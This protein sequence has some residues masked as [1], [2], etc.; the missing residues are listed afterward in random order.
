MS[1]TSQLEAKD[2][3][4]RKFFQKYE[5]KHAA[6]ECLAELQSSKPIKLPSYEP[7]SSYGQIWCMADL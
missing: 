2:S 6:S 7:A 5:D 1:L 4:V 3:P